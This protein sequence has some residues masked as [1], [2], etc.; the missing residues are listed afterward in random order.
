MSTAPNTLAQDARALL[1]IKLGD[2]RPLV[3]AGARDA[4]PHQVIAAG[5]EALAQLR[6]RQRAPEKRIRDA[7]T[8]WRGIG[9]YCQARARG[10]ARRPPT[11]SRA[12]QGVNCNG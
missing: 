10:K 8:T 1:A 2:G 11:G 3:P 12:D 9:D 7:T 6:R 5:L 4:G